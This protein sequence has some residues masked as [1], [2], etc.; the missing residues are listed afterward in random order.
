MKGPKEVKLMSEEPNNNDDFYPHR[1]EFIKHIKIVE[2]KT[3]GIHEEINRNRLEKL[4]KSIEA[5]GL[6]TCPIPACYYSATQFHE[7]GKVRSRDFTLVA[8]GMHRSAA[9]KELNLNYTPIM[10][11]DYMFNKGLKLDSWIRTLRRVEKRQFL[12]QLDDFNKKNLNLKRPILKKCDNK[13]KTELKESLRNED[14][15]DGLTLIYDR[16]IYKPFLGKKPL[17]EKSLYEIFKGDKIALYKEYCQLL[18]KHLKLQDKYH[19]YFETQEKLKSKLEKPYIDFDTA[20]KVYHHQKRITIFPP[21]LKKLDVVEVAKRNLIHKAKNEN[22]FPVHTTRHV[23]PLR[24]F[25]TP[26][27][28]ETLKSRDKTAEELTETVQ[29]ELMKVSDKEIIFHPK[30]AMYDG[31]WY[32]VPTVIFDTKRRI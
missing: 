22:L 10:D 15:P 25:G 8:D 30:D 7:N 19:W 29:S 6:F 16:E 14:Y 2:T 13:L 9:A 23:V 21:L 5:S 11:M 4:K 27:T 1:W 17:D 26:I 3:L 24:I 28:L 20:R 12:R 31:T 32:N 18:E